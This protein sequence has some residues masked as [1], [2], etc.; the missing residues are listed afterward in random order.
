M[1]T[2]P[3]CF[4][5]PIDGTNESL[6]PAR[7]LG[8]LYSPSEVRLILSYFSAPPPPAYTGD[9]ARSH[10]L[11]AKKRQFLEDEKRE[12]RAVFDHALEALEK[13]G[14]LKEFI[15]EHVEPKGMAVAKQACLLGDIKK[16]D[17]IVVPKHVKVRLE[18]LLKSDPSSALAQQCIE[19]PVWMTEGAIEPGKAAIYI[20]DEEGSTRIADHAGYMLSDTG[21]DIDLVGAAAKIRHPLTWR[22]SQA[23]SAPRGLESLLKASAVLA[24]Y[25]IDQ[26]RIRMTL[27]P[28]RGDTIAEVLSWCASNGIGIIGLERTRTEGIL[29]SLRA[30]STRKITSDLKNMAVWI[31]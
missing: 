9:L 31:A 14:F 6:W 26:D 15:Q 7:F 5:L 25:G 28:K 30:S 21:V 20:S 8:K 4:L 10:E 17:A 22:P 18:D 13:L 23:Q 27:I 29:G 3:K 16:V 12:E 11:Q 24:D 1:Q 2:I 19:C